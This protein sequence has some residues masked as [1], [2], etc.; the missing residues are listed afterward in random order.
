MRYHCFSLPSVLTAVA[1]LADLVMPLSTPWDDIHVKHT[2][3]S[4]PANWESLGPPLPS[5]K[6]DLY[7]ALQPQNEDAIIDT[8]YA[9]S[10]PGDPRYFLSSPTRLRDVL[11]C[12]VA[13]LQI[14]R[15][16]LNGR[17]G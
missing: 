13:P 15:T 3:N 12:V 9:V 4:V 8:L 2:W 1:L 7:V 16:P 11:M 5:T 14:W 6:I 10:T 17:G